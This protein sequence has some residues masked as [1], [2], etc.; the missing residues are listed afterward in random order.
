MN[1]DLWGFQKDRLRRKTRPDPKIR[2]KVLTASRSEPPSAETLLKTRRNTI[3]L[4]DGFR[5]H[6]VGGP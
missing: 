5:P 2:E 1:E 6:A 3:H 4:S